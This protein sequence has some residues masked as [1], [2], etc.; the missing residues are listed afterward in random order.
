MTIQTHFPLKTYNTF[1]IDVL[2]DSFAEVH[3]VKELQ[4][5]LA[6]AETPLI[7]GSGSNILF[8]K[9]YAGMVIRIAIKGIQMLQ[10]N[11]HSV[12]LEVGAGENWHALVMYC[13]E[14]NLGGVENLSL[15]PGTVGAAPVQ[16][17]GAYGVE[18]KDVLMSVTG[19]DLHSH[20]MRTL[21]NEECTFGYRSSIFKRELRNRFVITSVILRLQKH[22]VLHLTYPA[23]AQELKAH[24]SPLT[25]RDVS[26]AV[27]RVRRSKLP[28]PAELGNAGSFFKNPTIPQEQFLRLREQFPT[29]PSFPAASGTV[30]IPAGW[31]I[32]QCKWKGKRLGATGT[33]PLQ[34]LVIVNYGSATGSDILALAQE[35]QASV[36][37]RFDIVLE[38]EVNIV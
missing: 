13:V 24:T 10:E 35:I 33:Y 30:K 17:I 20:T 28:D 23:L 2:A 6:M 14:R 9:D 3:S 38:P 21:T 8:T 26:N 29:M 7:L 22:P 19:L 32:E 34:A 4:Q 31:L 18:L 1:G 15:I 12:Y 25:I 16:N 27:C 5:A 11:E 36:R 37:E